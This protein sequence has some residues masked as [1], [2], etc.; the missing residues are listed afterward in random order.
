ML[1]LSGGISPRPRRQAHLWWHLRRLAVFLPILYPTP[2]PE[3]MG[4]GEGGGEKP[5]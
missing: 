5:R 3:K 2:G 1:G 4:G